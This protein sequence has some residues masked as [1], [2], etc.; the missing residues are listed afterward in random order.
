M[1]GNRLRIRPLRERQAQERQ[2]ADLDQGQDV[3][4]HPLQ[5]L[6][7]NI[8]LPQRKRKA[9]SSPASESKGV[10][11]SFSLMI[12]TNLFASDLAG[13]ERDGNET[14]RAARPPRP[15]KSVQGHRH[16]HRRQ[17]GH[18]GGKG[19]QYNYRVKS[20]ITDQTL[21]D[22]EIEKIAKT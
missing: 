18:S 15:A 9:A 16:P 19:S 4:E 13:H 12:L 17:R 3:R 14:I 5:T 20:V 6:L 21:V 1:W 8:H 22:Q 10:T 2:D 7:D 11:N